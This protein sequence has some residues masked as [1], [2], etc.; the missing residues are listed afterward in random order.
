MLK[1]YLPWVVFILLFGFVFIG[2][3]T[4]DNMNK[5][6]SEMMINQASPELISKGNTLID[7]MYNY[8]KNEQSY[9]ITFLEFGAEN[10]SACR[11]MVKV[12]DEIEKKYPREVK[13]V[14]LNILFAE[15]QDLMKYYGIASIPTQVLL[16]K[17]GVET[18]RHTG[19]ISMEVLLKE[20]NIE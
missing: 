14:F 8:E 3:Y 20:V 7:S 1:K 12:M 17:K 6:V 13:V 19:Y 10:C 5:Y 15:S 4:I 16:D 11:K 2:F 9:Q 18:Y